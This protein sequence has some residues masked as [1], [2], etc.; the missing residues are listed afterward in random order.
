MSERMPPNTRILRQPYAGVYSVQD[1]ALFLRATTPPPA[2]PL[3]LW[4][5]QRNQFVGPTSRHVYN[6]I[7]RS[8]NDYLIS[9]GHIALTFQQL[10]RS[11]MIV[12]FRARGLSL[13]SILSAET[14]IRTATG[15]PQPFVAEHLW[16]SSSDMFFELERNIRAAT[17]PDQ[18]VFDDVIREYMTPIHHGLEFDASGLSSL[19]RPMPGIV[20]DPEIQFGSPCIENTRIETEAI[21]SFH[22]AGT[23]VRRL[24]S[25]YKVDT[26]AIDTALKWEGL[27]D[28][29][30]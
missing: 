9:N 1:A 16:S 28:R 10:I 17:K 26:G 29:A 25:L 23:S 22:H 2:I 21:W 15:N 14:N 6:W 30:A 4:E 11:R 20:I 3:Q 7:R 13:K 12:L 19:W 24:A 27:L 18:L 8:G 5:R